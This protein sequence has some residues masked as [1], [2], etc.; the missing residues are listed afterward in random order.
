MFDG[1]RWEVEDPPFD[2]TNAPESTFSGFGTWKRDADLLV[3]IDDEG[4]VVQFTRW[5]GEA[6]EG[7]CA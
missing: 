5:N 4:A 7:I 3:F 2:A 6:D 1:V